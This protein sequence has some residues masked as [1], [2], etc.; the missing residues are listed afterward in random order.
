MAMARAAHG[1]VHAAGHGT[2]VFAWTVLGRMGHR[3]LSQ[4][5]RQYGPFEDLP[6]ERWLWLA[7]R[8]RVRGSLAL[9]RSLALGPSLRVNWLHSHRPG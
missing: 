3:G 8:G 6:P 7:V 9:S 2:A 4:V 5:I 1:A